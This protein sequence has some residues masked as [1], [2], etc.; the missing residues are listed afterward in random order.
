MEK[1]ENARET[2]T[3]DEIWKRQKKQEKQT[4]QMKCEKEREKHGR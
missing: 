1:T 3:V 2:N 4:L